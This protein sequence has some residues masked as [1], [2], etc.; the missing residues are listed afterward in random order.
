VT[1]RKAIS[2]FISSIRILLPKDVTDD[3]GKTSS[4]TYD[5][6]FAKKIE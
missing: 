5:L 2:Y 6:L 4:V 1:K 3:S